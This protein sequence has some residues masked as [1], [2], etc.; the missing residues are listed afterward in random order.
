LLI[1]ISGV[2]VRE[3]AALTGYAASRS[4]AAPTAASSHVVPTTRERASAASLLAL[5]PTSAL[6]ANDNA[7]AV[8]KS[9]SLEKNCQAAPLAQALLASLSNSASSSASATPRAI[10][11]DLTAPLHIQPLHPTV[12]KILNVCVGFLLMAGVPW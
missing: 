2:D 8:L 4:R 11:V 10:N 12:E 6:V 3:K 1:L 7:A 5:L 9:V